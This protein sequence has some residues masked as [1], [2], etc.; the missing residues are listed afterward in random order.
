MVLVVDLFCGLKGWSRPFLD[1]G[2]EVVTLDVDDRFAPTIRAD[3]C[4]VRGDS[5]PDNVDIVL[6]SPPCEHFSVMSIGRNWNKDHTPKTAEALYAM[7][8]VHQT[9]RL[10]SEIQPRAFIIENPRGKL[11]KLPPVED[12]E[13]R[14]VWYCRLGEAVAKPT[15]LW[16]GFPEGLRLP[17]ECRNGNDDH[18]AAP[19]GSKTG[20]QGVGKIRPTKKNLRRGSMNLTK[21]FMREYYGTSDPAELAAQRAKVPYALGLTVCLAMEASSPS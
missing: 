14:T 5:F 3:I 21:A 12:L 17:A 16:G 9:R 1:R 10:I 6:A 8:L 15:D 11:R 19:R 7:E 20:T 18:L 13:R 2:H 4:S